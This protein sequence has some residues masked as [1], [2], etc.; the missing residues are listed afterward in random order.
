M[1]DVNARRTFLTVGQR[2]T[3]IIAKISQHWT[4]HFVLLRISRK[5]K[6]RK[7]EEKE[8]KRQSQ[9]DSNLTLLSFKPFAN[10]NFSW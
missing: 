2:G 6:E 1:S 10:D 3:N 7:K 9:R 8:R 5:R 4:N